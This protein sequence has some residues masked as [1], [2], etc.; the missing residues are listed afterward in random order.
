MRWI[1]KAWAVIHVQSTA[2]HADKLKVYKHFRGTRRLHFQGQGVSQA[3][4]HQE[5]STYQSHHHVD[6]KSNMQRTC[7]ESL[8]NPQ[9]M[10]YY[11]FRRGWRG[12]C[13]CNN[14]CIS[15]FS[16]WKLSIQS[17]HEHSSPSCKFSNW[18]DGCGLWSHTLVCMVCLQ[19]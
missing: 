10:S 13:I 14:Y 8:Y 17:Q 16:S 15:C 19:C 11:C 4:S 3:S 7:L 1:H 2:F 6:L 5:A 12:G 9:S 18:C